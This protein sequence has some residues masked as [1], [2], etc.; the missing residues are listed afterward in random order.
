M[1]LQDQKSL[2]RVLE[3]LRDGREHSPQEIGH[4]C[5]A[6]HNTIL[7]DIKFLRDRGYVI[8]KRRIDNEQNYYYL[9]RLDNAEGQQALEI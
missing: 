3:Y 2:D 4:I 1:V 6:Q 7:K 9:Y 8:T 5:H